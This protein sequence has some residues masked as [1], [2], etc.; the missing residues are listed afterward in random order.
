MA[1]GDPLHLIGT[2]TP[3]LCSTLLLPLLLL[4]FLG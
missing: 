1:Q 4:L 3:N 2:N